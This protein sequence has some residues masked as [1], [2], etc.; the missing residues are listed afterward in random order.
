M[1]EIQ[2]FRGLKETSIP[3]VRITRSKK[4]I[5]G[6]AIFYFEEPTIFAPG[7]NQEVTGLYLIDEEGELT[8]N[9]V[10]GTFLNGKPK[11][12]EATY[13]MKSKD[14][15]DRF[16]RFMERYGKENGLELTKS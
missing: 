11:A 13:V 12:I 10:K 5:N 15:W 9:D 4:R 7:T 8:S 3:D 1:A 6:A 2:F 14:D 16:M